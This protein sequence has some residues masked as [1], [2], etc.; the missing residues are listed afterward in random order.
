MKQG[1]L[2]TALA[3]GFVSCDKNDDPPQGPSKTDMVTSAAWKYDNGG[4]DSNGDGTIDFTFEQTGVVQPCRLDNTALFKADGT[5][6]TDEGATK[7]NTTDPQTAA[8]N[9]NFLNN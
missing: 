2:L 3:L 6:V 1:I 8:F 7:C 5:G 9:W 4:A